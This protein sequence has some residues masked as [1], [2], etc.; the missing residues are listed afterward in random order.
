[1]IEGQFGKTVDAEPLG[2]IRIG[3]GSQLMVRRVDQSQIG[4][5]NHPVPRIA[6]HIAERVELFKKIGLYTGFF[7]KFTL[8]R[9]IQV[10]IIQNQSARKRPSALKGSIFR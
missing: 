9:I 7:A 3:I 1:M 10:F 4:Y 5:G 6:A 8:Y 2:I